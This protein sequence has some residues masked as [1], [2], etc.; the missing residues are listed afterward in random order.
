MIRRG[1][2]T[3]LLAILALPG[4]GCDIGWA[5]T[6]SRLVTPE[7]TVTLAADAPGADGT[8]RGTLTIDLAPGWHTYWRDPGL[9]GIPPS[10]DFAATPNLASADL[11][12]P[13][14]IRFGE[15]AA[16]AV[17][18]EGRA[19]LAFELRPAAGEA[20]S[21][22]AA[23]VLV[24]VCRDICVPVTADLET[25]AAGSSRAIERAFARLPALAASGV[26]IEHEAAASRLE[27][28]VDGQA[29][30]VFLD[31]PEGWVL[32]EASRLDGG[33][34]TTKFTVPI[35]ARPRDEARALET[36][37]VVVEDGREQGRL[38]RRVPVHGE[39]EI[40]RHAEEAH[41]NAQ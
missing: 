3:A 23:K 29:A 34:G 37:D 40:A 18:Y 16:R 15:E 30:D 9:S 35:L 17:G 22:V 1:F 5:D 33:D 31:A 6:T 36:I 39:G 21:T 41:Q 8:V 38:L 27:V 10:V 24:G 11:R 14:P 25:E 12:F 26:T 7:A 20:L 19:K 2:A 32:D 28:T 4:V 13:V